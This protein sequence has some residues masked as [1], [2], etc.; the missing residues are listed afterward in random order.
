MAKRWT[1]SEEI[2]Y[3]NQLQKLY[4]SENKTISAISSILKISPSAVYD[5]L[6]RLK[7][8]TA[9][10]KKAHYLNKRS[11][12]IIPRRRSE[13]L[14]EFFGIMLG[15]GKLSHFQIAVTLGNKEATYAAY[16]AGLFYKLFGVSPKIITS[17]KKG[18]RVVYLGS[19]EIS[20]WLIAEGLVYNKVAAQVDA[21]HW[22]LD[23]KQYM[24]RFIRGF[25]D[26][27]GSIYKLKHGTQLSF[28]NYSAPLL[29]SLQWS[30][31]RLGYRV[32]EIS[33]HRF[34]LTKIDGI[35]RFFKEIQPHNQRHIKRFNLFVN[36]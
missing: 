35:K 3:V 9:P 5:R 23:K 25:F 33:G 4:I 14:A 17:V 6:I 32:S 22:I 11:D 1:H 26:T 24:K 13:A 36:L 29:M 8:P 10:E 15:D 31:R 2:F 7:I 12:V 16:V 34:Y 27:D 30:L 28:T 18:Y 21:P 19:T 20:T